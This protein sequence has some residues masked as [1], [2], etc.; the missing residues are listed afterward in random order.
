VQFLKA[1]WLKGVLIGAAAALVPLTAFADFV[2]VSGSGVTVVTLAPGAETFALDLGTVCAGTGTSAPVSLAIGARS[3]PDGT[4]FIFAD[5]STANLSATSS[6]GGLSASIDA[7]GSIVLPA[8]WTSLPDGTLSSALGST[9]TLN[10]STTGAFSGTITYAASGVQASGAALTKFSN[11]DVT[12]TVVNCAGDVSVKKTAAASSIQAGQVASFS[13]VVT[14]LG[15]SD[16][17][18]VVLTDV[19]PSGLTWTV[20]GADATAAGCA[21]T[22]A[23]GS[24]LTCNFGTLAVGATRSVTIS[25]TTTAANCGELPNTAVVSASNDS[26]SGNNSSSASMT[27]TCPSTAQFAPTQTTC[28]QFVAGTAAVENAIHYN[29][30]NG[31]INNVSPGVLFYYTTVTAPANGTFTVTVS[32]TDNGSTPPLGAAQLQLFTANC[33]TYSNF[34]GSTNAAGTSTFTINGATA[35]QVFIIAVKVDPHTV[36]GSPTPSPATVTYT[37]TTSVNG[38]AIPSSVQQATLAP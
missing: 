5:G 19:L 27:V 18:N 1:R 30:K 38:V 22:L 16:A 25:A 24:T 32:Q 14:S 26:N 31:V 2:N 29:L 10:T 13:I 7:P 3:H 37:Y 33:S 15:P 6:G 20:S 36:V 17:S 4:F 28:Q 12:A 9:V 23:G 21:G 34:S 8:N 35:G 11:L